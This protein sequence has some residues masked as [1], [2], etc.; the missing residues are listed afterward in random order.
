MRKYLL[1]L[2]L[3]ALVCFSAYAQKV[4]VENLVKPLTT[5]F[6]A[7]KEGTEVKGYYLFWAS[8]KIDKKSYEWTLRITDPALKTL[9][10]IKMQE[11]KDIA[12]LETSF[13]GTDLI[14]LFYN[15]DSRTFDYQVYGA[16]GKKKWTYMRQ[17]TKKEEKYL[18]ATYLLNDDEQTYKGL[19]PIEGLGF[20]SNMPSREDKDYTFQIDFLGTDKKKQWT[21]IPAM[22]GKKFLGDYLG[23][24]NGIVYLEVLKFGSMM[25]AKPE[26]VIVGLDLA[27][28][29]QLFE[30]P[31]D[32]KY[33]FYPASMS[34][35]IDGKNYIYGEYFDTNGNVI[36]DKSL[37][38]G[39]W[40]VD[41]KGAI[42]SEKYLSWDLHLGKFLNVTSKGK[43]ED[44][45]YMFL[46]NMVQTSTGEIYA[47]GEGYKKTASA[48][49]IISKVATRGGGLSAIKIKVTD[50]ILIQ[51]D[52]DFNVKGAKIYE[53]NANNIEL[54]S[55][56]EVVSGPALGKLIKYNFG[57]FDYSYTQTSKD[58]SSFTVAY[59]DYERGKGYKGSSFNAISYADGKVTQDKIRTKSDATRSFVL[60]A[61]QGS[62]MILD[63]Y[64]KDKKLE[65][66]IE[67]LN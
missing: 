43:I 52:K 14:I 13:N 59:A 4:S 16:D 10:E 37:G 26:S 51:F 2:M 22:S 11:S 44:F 39:F 50:L 42:K 40:N 67:K 47:I 5:D 33:R 29:R 23:T 27:N 53:K 30:K 57:G 65:G 41:E 56:A 15:D 20:I 46:H 61:A 36:K 25:D 62:V 49:G 34:V 21:Y 60:P 1:S 28:G 38:F 48:L 7:I 55:G 63:I 17:L 66:H 31:T 8:D 58:L 35:T 12:I 54:P 18:E 64:K 45:G 24:V 32:G 3:L 9:K 6:G 19:F